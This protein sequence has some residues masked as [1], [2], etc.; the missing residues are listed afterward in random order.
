MGL[1]KKKKTMIQALVKGQL[2]PIENVEDPVFSSGAMG[3]GFAIKPKENL[4]Y[5]PVDGRIASIFPTKHAIVIE[6]KDGIQLLIH[7]GLDT[8]ELNGEGFTLTISEGDYVSRGDQIA[9]IDFDFIIKQGKGNTV[10]VVFL[11]NTTINP[12]I[13]IKEVEAKEDIFEI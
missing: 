7:I 1:F 10:V 5:S 2:I 11:E 12:I 6:T 4:L 9:N 3:K 13:E 8:G